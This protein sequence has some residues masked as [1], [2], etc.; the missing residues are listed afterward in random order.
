M[1]ELCVVQNM[2]R[3]RNT[4]LVIAL[5]ALLVGASWWLVDRSKNEIAIHGVLSEG[6]R[7][8]IIDTDHGEL[9]G[10]TFPILGGEVDFGRGF[11]IK[12]SRM[13][14]R[15]SDE[16]GTHYEGDLIVDPSGK[17]RLSIPGSTS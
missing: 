10:Q 6:M 13:L 5:L 8:E 9:L 3:S 7:F 12:G 11:S 14:I 17:T 16:T 15:I 2:N 1:A 4:I